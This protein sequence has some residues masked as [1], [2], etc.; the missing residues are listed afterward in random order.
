MGAEVEVVAGKLLPVEALAGDARKPVQESGHFCP[1]TELQQTV[2]IGLDFEFSRVRFEARIVRVGRGSLRRL[3]L[4][5]RMPLSRASSVRRQGKRTSRRLPASRAWIPNF[6]STT[7]VAIAA[8]CVVGST[9]MPPPVAGPEYTS[10]T[11][12]EYTG[13]A[14]ANRRPNRTG[15]IT[16]ALNSPLR[17]SCDGGS[18]AETDKICVAADYTTFAPQFGLSPCMTPLDRRQPQ[19]PITAPPA[20]G[21]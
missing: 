2:F 1:R 9:A 8:G 7:A 5:Q 6:S 4:R 18:K 16:A 12:C 13:R 20:A 11:G 3:L 17:G 21:P 19:S 14:I 15:Q 10:T